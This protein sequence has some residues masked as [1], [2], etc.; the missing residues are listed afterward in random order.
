MN[1]ST[2]SLGTRILGAVAAVGCVA[3]VIFA[4]GV[5]PADAEL[6]E[7]IRIMYVH[8]PTVT[9]AYMLLIANALFSGYYLWKRSD[10]A[11]VA[12]HT[13]A[14]IGVLMLGLTLVTGSL[15]G[16]I[17]WGTF[18]EWDARLTTTALLFLLYVGYLALRAATD[19]PRARATRAAVLGIASAFLI[20]IVHKSVDWWASLHQEKTLFGTADPSIDGS[21]LFTLMLSMAV[22]GV[23]AVWLSMH[24]FRVGWLSL[25]VD[26]MRVE[27]AIEE[28]RSEGVAA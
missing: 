28:R 11:D 21:Q 12:A 19:D 20:P 23:L 9:A 24:R 22:F 7:S 26:R 18:W 4:F 6:G 15:W 5:S 17:T 2:G 14:E 3:V 8:V 25:Q 16:R 1:Q 13:T 10:F 27:K